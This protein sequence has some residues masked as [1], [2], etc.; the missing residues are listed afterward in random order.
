MFELLA[1]QLIAKAV[2]HDFYTHWKNVFLQVN[3]F[4]LTINAIVLFKLGERLWIFNTQKIRL[5]FFLL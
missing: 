3:N 1:F 2:D 4:N 5:L